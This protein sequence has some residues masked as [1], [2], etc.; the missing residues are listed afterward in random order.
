MKWHRLF[1]S[2][3]TTLRNSCPDYWTLLCMRL[4][5]MQS[6]SGWKRRCRGG[7]AVLRRCAIAAAH[8]GVPQGTD[9][10]RVAIHAMVLVVQVIPD[11]V[12]L[13]G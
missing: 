6:V 4:S 10:A 3:A 8:F 11:H 5:M 2:A 9:E 12:R 13:H 1:T 7:S